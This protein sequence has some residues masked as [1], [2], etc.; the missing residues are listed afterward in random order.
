MNT[1]QNHSLILQR[2]G[3][4]PEMIAKYSSRPAQAKTES[5]IHELE[6]EAARTQQRRCRVLYKRLGLTTHGKPRKNKQTGIVAETRA[7]WM[8]KYRLWRKQCAASQ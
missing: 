8:K 4:T 7:E 5:E 3:V 2:I 1:L 6:L